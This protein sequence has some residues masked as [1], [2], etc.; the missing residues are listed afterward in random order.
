MNERGSNF[1]LIVKYVVTSVIAGAVGWFM[2]S[3]ISYW[4]HPA[5]Q[6]DIGMFYRD[7][8]SVGALFSCLFTWIVFLPSIIVLYFVAVRVF[9]NKVSDTAMLVY[10]LFLSFFLL[11]GN[12]VNLAGLIFGSLLPEHAGV[13]R[14][15]L[16]TAIFGTLALLGLARFR[17]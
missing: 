16:I 10:V 2:G 4:T 6:S 9:K 3:I 17:K 13:L 15:L 5:L 14:Y 1:R 12:Q 8:F 7:L 11:L